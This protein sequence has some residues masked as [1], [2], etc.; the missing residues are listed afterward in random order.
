LATKKEL[1]KLFKDE[2]NWKK[3]EQF[4]KEN[5]RVTIEKEQAELVKKG[6]YN[7]ICN[8]LKHPEWITER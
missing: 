4:A 6:F 3:I 8:E 5:R 1:L 7:Y 2:K